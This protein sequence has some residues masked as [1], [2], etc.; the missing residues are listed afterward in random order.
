MRKLHSKGHL[1]PFWDMQLIKEFEFTRQPLT[2]EEETLW[3]SQGYDYIK[4][5]T[6]KMFDSRNPMPDWVDKFGSKFTDFKNLTYTFYKMS[7]LEIMPTHS[8]HYRT[9]MRL[10]NTEA[11][12]ICRILVMLEDWKPGHY[13][14]ID[15]VGIVN[16]QAGDYF[17]WHNDC[18]HAASNIGIQDRYTLQITAELR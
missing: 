11:K 7:T 13:L 15:Q 17:I 5:F 12:N 10:F 3:K 18:P 6:G 9:Y 4:S 8:D 16:W 1:D 2:E 14:E